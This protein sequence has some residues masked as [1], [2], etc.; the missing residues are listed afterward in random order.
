M[1][2]EQNT[3]SNETYR[4]MEG[5]WRTRCGVI[6]SKL[7]G[8]VCG[9]NA[10]PRKTLLL[11]LIK[12]GNPLVD[13]E[14]KSPPSRKTPLLK[15][16]THNNNTQQKKKSIDRIVYLSQKNAAG[17]TFICEE[18]SDQN[19]TQNDTEIH[20]CNTHYY[21]HKTCMKPVKRVPL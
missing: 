15:R 7:C 8:A 20:F 16:S 21:A 12:K 4:D 9:C 11:S 17:H 2:L 5:R 18:K 10:L 19:D 3:Q 13:K 6:K 14:R 1:Q